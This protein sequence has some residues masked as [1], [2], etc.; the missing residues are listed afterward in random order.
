MGL[1]LWDVVR[2]LE[3]GYDCGTG[4]RSDEIFERCLRIQGQEVKV[5]GKHVGWEPYAD[6]PA[7]VFWHIKETGRSS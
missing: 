5:V 3:E 4:P 7:W 1:T 2:I 6:G